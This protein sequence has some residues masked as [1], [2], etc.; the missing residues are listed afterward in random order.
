MIRTFR[1]VAL[2]LTAPAVM[3]LSFAASGPAAAAVAHPAVGCTSSASDPIKIDGFAFTPAAVPPGGS[4]TADL[5]TT[6]CSN[7]SVTTTEEWLAQWLPL[8]G[9]GGVATG[10]PILDPLIRSAVYGP[11]QE[12]AENTGYTVPAGCE[13]AEL[14]VTVRIS[15]ASSGV[16]ETATADLVIEHVSPGS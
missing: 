9:A 7:T 12:L 8:T 3:G 16:V 1:N 4:S 15:V 14:A 11:G 13:A 6:N 10:C 5:I 2:L